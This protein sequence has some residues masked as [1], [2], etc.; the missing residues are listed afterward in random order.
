MHWSF[1]WPSTP[2]DCSAWATKAVTTDPA[3][4]VGIV[5]RYGVELTSSPDASVA[6]L[7][8]RA[9]GRLSR[10]DVFPPT[11]MRPR[12]CSRTG[13]VT[14]DVVIIQRV[15]LGIAVFEAAVKVVATWDT[16]DESGF[17][18]ATLEGHPERGISTFRV[19][20][21]GAIVRF[22]IEAVS[23][24]GSPITRVFRPISRRFQVSATRAAL[25]Y[26]ASAERSST[27]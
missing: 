5:D 25:A 9:R 13:L 19:V 20:R 23:Q 7:F 18:Y 15:R 26:F 6:A 1:T 12:V 4:P 21:E 2:P 11:L 16:T 17:T 27:A 24:P 10:Y 3:S 14:K 8:E 22:E